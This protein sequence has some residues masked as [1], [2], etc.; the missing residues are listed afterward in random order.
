M[1]PVI[2]E[3]KRHLRVLKNFTQ[4]SLF[5][6]SNATFYSNGKARLN[7]NASGHPLPTI[8]W[9]INDEVVNEDVKVMGVSI[10]NNSLLLNGVS[11]LG[12][13]YT[14]VA[15]NTFGS[16]NATSYIQYFGKVKLVIIKRGMYD[17]HVVIFGDD[18]W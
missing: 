14:C 17:Y 6:G 18:H 13:A 8:T 10:Q 3:G 16:Y 15:S 4:H 7:C 12:G 2:S 1:L 9:L 5:A 11:R